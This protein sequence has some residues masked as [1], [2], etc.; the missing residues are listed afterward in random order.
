MLCVYGVVGEWVHMLI[1]RSAS[2]LQTCALGQAG[3]VSNTSLGQLQG[4]SLV[5]PGAGHNQCCSTGI[6]HAQYTLPTAWS[7]GSS[8]WQ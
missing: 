8:W 7:A 1:H 2:Q 6:Q 5:P 4:D 3:S